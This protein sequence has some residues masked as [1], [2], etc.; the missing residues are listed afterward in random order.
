MQSSQSTT[1]FSTSKVLQQD[2]KRISI[3]LEDIYWNQLEE[4]AKAE[5]KTLVQLVHQILWNLP[6][7]HNKTSAL[8]VFCLMTL[9]G[10]V[11]SV[12]MNQTPA[13]MKGFLTAC[14]L[15]V[16]VLSSAR[17]IIAFNAAFKSTFLTKKL[18][19]KLKG[20]DNLPPRL[21]FSQPLNRIISYLNT[22]PQKVITGQ[23]GFMTGDNNYYRG[24]RYALINDSHVIVFVDEGVIPPKI[25]GVHK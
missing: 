6:K 25:S 13:N 16:F 9:Q 19:T 12:H 8:R 3:R 14:P 7:P 21:T 5:G 22:H 15:P 20:G 24:V 23:M 10:Q 1:I 18:A 4:I 2:G 11:N 17:K